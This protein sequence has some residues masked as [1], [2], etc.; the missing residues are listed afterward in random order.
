VVAAA[1][2]MSACT[3]SHARQ[4]APS[5]TP[6]TTHAQE[7]S[8]QP[9]ASAEP[10]LVLVPAGA[11]LLREC[12]SVARQVGYGVPCPRLLPQGWQGSN[13]GPA[14]SRWTAGWSLLTVGFPVDTSN[15]W[16]NGFHAGHLVIDASPSPAGPKELLCRFSGGDSLFAAGSTRVNGTSAHWYRVLCPESIFL[17]HLAVVWTR[18][19]HTYAVGFHDWT[20]ESRMYGLQVAQSVVLVGST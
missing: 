14:M 12:R 19:G 5:L 17:G 10:A 15:L 8:A 2:I 20:K 11:A 18:A 3:F 16:A 4:A 6:P 7:S 1:V 9:E 13:G